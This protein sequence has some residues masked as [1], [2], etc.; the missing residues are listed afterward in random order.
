MTKTRVCESCANYKPHTCTWRPV[1]ARPFWL[2]PM[3]GNALNPWISADQDADRCDAYE[4]KSD[5][6]K[7]AST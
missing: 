7:G 6:M 3:F 5:T 4:E 1:G 2:D